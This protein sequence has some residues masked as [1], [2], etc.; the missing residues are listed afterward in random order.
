MKTKDNYFKFTYPKPD[1]LSDAKDMLNKI[2]KN[3]F[4][5]YGVD[6]LLFK[7]SIEDNMLFINI[8][9]PNDPSQSIDLTYYFDNEDNELKLLHKSDNN[10]QSDVESMEELGSLI[11][12][13]I[14]VSENNNIITKIDNFKRS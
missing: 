7:E 6:S 9:N 8:S 13:L 3:L 11:K 4:N 5:R 14:R 1:W 10:P 12:P 2:K